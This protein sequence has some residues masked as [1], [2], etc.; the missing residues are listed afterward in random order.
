[1]TCPCS[2]HSRVSGIRIVVQG[3]DF[4]SGGPKRQVEW[5]EKVMDKHFESKHTVVASSDLAESLVM[6]NTKI[7][8]QDNGIAYIPDKSTRECSWE[9]MR[10]SY[11]QSEK[12]LVRDVLNADKTS[13]YRSAV[14]RLSCWAVDRPDMQHAV[15]IC[16]K[17]CLAQEPM[18]GRDP[19]AWQDT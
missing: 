18:I 19:S 10:A 7:V 2:F 6:L 9:S 12:A 1:M 4:M 14:A 11:S 16:S 3:D 17:S 5:L 13:L 8:W 15:R